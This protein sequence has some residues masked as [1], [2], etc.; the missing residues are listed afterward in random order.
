MPGRLRSGESSQAGTEVHGG[1]QVT[2]QQQRLLSSPLGQA[3]G[4]ARP[5]G[6]SEPPWA[7]PPWEGAEGGVPGSSQAPHL[8]SG[9][10]ISWVCVDTRSRESTQAVSNL[11]PQ[12]S[13]LHELPRNTSLGQAS[14]WM[15]FRAVL[16]LSNAAFV[17][18][19]LMRGHWSCSSR[20][21]GWAPGPGLYRARSCPESSP[22]VRSQ[23]QRTESSCLFENLEA[24]M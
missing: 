21:D 9:K 12:H 15:A 24:I 8:C 16:T 1:L 4:K 23:Q 6:Q 10:S 19:S 11:R 18:R 13:G 22:L 2:C 5:V 17:S 20:E 14:I 3:S 7:W